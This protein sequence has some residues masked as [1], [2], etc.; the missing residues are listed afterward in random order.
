MTPVILLISY[1][2][3]VSHLTSL[4]LFVCLFSF[5]KLMEFKSSLLEFLEK[6]FHSSRILT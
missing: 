2:T 3:Q 1:V 4:D 5:F 6:E